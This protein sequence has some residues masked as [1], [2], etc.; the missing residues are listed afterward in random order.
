MFCETENFSALRLRS[1]EDRKLLS[2]PPPPQSFTRC[3]SATDVSSATLQG[4][5]KKSNS[6]AFKFSAT[7]TKDNRRAEGPCSVCSLQRG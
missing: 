2:P 4:A 5:E 3:V 6:Q 7:E 1:S